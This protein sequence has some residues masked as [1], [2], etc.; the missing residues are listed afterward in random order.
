[1]RHEAPDET[2]LGKKHI[3]TTAV[4]D[5]IY[6]AEKLNQ[7]A[8][9]LPEETLPLDSFTEAIDEDHTY[10]ID[11]EGN[12]LGPADILRDWQRAQ[13]NPA[14][15]EHIAIIRGANLNRPIWIHKESRQV[16]NGVHRLTRAFLDRLPE[17]KA[18][19]FENLPDSAIVSR[20]EP[21][22]RDNPA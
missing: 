8:E 21:G 11:Q 12:P 14:W 17:I 4:G 3:E 19:V 9:A 18:K 5:K 20:R 2:S 1:M 22:D 10:W 16:I 7:F 13:E 15:A 6:D